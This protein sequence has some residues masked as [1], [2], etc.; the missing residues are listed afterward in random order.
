MKLY[1]FLFSISG[2]NVIFGILFNKPGC[3]IIGALGLLAFAF[4][5]RP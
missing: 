3:I 4:L 1:S 2:V 5:P